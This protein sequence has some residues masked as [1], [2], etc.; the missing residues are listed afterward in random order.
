MVYYGP[1]EGM[2]WTVAIIAPKSDV[3]K[4]FTYMSIILALIA[5][6]GIVAVWII[7]RQIKYAEKT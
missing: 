7:C 2:E 6:L 1:I 5:V 4:P 3:Q